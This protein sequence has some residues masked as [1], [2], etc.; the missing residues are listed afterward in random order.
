VAAALV[1]AFLCLSAA[2]GIERADAREAVDARL[3]LVVDDFGYSFG[4]LV[5]AFLELPSGVAMS[6]VPG[7]PH[8]R[9]IALAAR[10]AGHPVLVHLPME[11]VGYPK[12]DPGKGA[13]MVADSDS[14]V[15]AKVRAA[16]ALVP[17]AE[18]LSNHMGSKA[19]S[20]ARIVRIVIEET[21]AAGLYFFDSKT[22]PGSPAK[23][24]ARELGVGFVENGRYWDKGSTPA[25]EIAAGLAQLAR[26]AR[27]RGRAVG[28][29]HPNKRS[30]EA[31]SAFLGSAMM[32]GVRLAPLGEMLEPK[33]KVATGGG[34][35]VDS[36]AGSR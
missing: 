7:T 34:A 26:R 12:Q 9:E 2:A 20:D 14:T 24:I 33:A 29:G 4:P 1:A 28:I 17:G 18:G 23:E 31:L 30:L 25:D 16:I 15:R 35:G 21:R 27:T 3:A 6:V 36:A 32:E 5:R 10:E 13:V 11:P 22:A 19:M 8:A